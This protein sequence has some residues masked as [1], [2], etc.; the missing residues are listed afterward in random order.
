MMVDLLKLQIPQ[1]VIHRIQKLIQTYHFKTIDRALQGC[2]P[3]P[4][5]TAR[6]NSF[7]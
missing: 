5:A 3:G 7:E 2:Q 1:K 4:L 6:R